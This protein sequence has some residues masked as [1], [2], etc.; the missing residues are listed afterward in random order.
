MFRSYPGSSRGAEVT[1][2]TA[3]TGISDGAAAVLTFQSLA[4]DTD[5]IWNAANNRMVVPAGVN[6]V[7]VFATAQVYDP[8]SPY[9]SQVR[10][11]ICRNGTMVSESY[12]QMTPSYLR[13][14]KA[15]ITWEGEVTPGDYF[16]V[17][18][19]AVG[20]GTYDLSNWGLF[21]LRVIE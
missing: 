6:R 15:A 10:L 8:A 3:Q 1:K 16:D 5:G 18:G 19:L 17:Q 4:R 2:T 9:S 21:L 7:H 11:M 12:V 20:S 14:L 13:G